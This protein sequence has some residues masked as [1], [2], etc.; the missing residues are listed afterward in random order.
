YQVTSG[1][2]MSG[3]SFSGALSRDPGENVGTYPIRQNTLSAGSDYQV[4]YLGANLVIGSWSLTGFYQ[5]VTMGD[6]VLN[7]VKG[8]STVPLKFNVYQGPGNTNERTDVAAVKKFVV[9]VAPCTSG[10]IQDEVDFVTTGGTTLRYDTTA[11][12][13]IQNWQTPR[14]PGAC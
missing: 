11:L 4:V 8:G 12:Q 9:E 14:T 2:L 6:W 1:T 13:F 5:P 3:D 7:T 10:T